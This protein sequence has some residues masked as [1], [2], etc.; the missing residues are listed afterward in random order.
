M[1]PG[2]YAPDLFEWIMILLLIVL[3]AV[4]SS[5]IPAE[6]LLGAR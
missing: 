2:P 4:A 3:S 5:P 6:I 1:K